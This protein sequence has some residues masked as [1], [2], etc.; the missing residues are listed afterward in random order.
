VSKLDDLRSL[1][2]RASAEVR[3]Y[4]NAVTRTGQDAIALEA[5]KKWLELRKQIIQLRSEIP[6]VPPELKAAIKKWDRIME[7]A[8]DKG[9][10]VLAA[11]LEETKAR[12]SD[13]GKEMRESTRRAVEVSNQIREIKDD[14]PPHAK[15]FAEQW[16]R[17]K[18]WAEPLDDAQSAEFNAAVEEEYERWRSERRSSP[19]ADAS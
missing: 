19:E 13:E 2:E 16:L 3:R 17:E 10:L 5:S 14:F 4:E 11:E 9:V 1:V 7:F 12:L 18:G 15:R 6:D 8:M